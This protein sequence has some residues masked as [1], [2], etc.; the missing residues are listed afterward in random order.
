MCLHAWRITL[1][2]PDNNEP[3]TFVA[4]AT[5]VGSGHLISIIEGFCRTITAFARSY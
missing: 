1:N 5:S 2:H 4:N 3:I